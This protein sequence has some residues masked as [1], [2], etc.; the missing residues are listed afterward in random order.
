MH[1]LHLA[2]VFYLQLFASLHGVSLK[3]DPYTIPILNVAALFGWTVPNIFADRYGALNV[4]MGCSIITGA[5]ILSMLRATSSGGVIAFAILYGFFSG[6]TISLTA[7][8]FALFAK[9]DEEIGMH[10]GIGTFSFSFALLCGNPISGTFLD[11]P[12][13][14]W[15]QPILFNAVRAYFTSRVLKYDSYSYASVLYSLELP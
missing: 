15:T 13:Y 14:F 1:S 6:G 9:T 7:P 5:V 3:L 11:S 2:S 4:F 8:V 10:I 12:H